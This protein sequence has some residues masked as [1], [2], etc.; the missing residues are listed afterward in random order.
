M[1]GK[2][3]KRVDLADSMILFGIGLAV[4]YWIFQSFILLFS[5]PD[6][7]F[8]QQ[9]RGTD[10]NVLYGRLTVFC[11]FILF[12]SHVQFNINKRKKAE[13]TLQKSEEKYRGILKSIEEGYY[14]VDSEFNFKFFNDSMC[15][16][17]GFT[18]DELID[19]NARQYMDDENATKVKK[20]FDEIK[21]T[22]KP[23]KTFDCEFI[24][25]GGH[26]RIIELSV[27]LIAGS[28]GKPLGFRGISRDVTEKKLLEKSLLD[29]YEEV[30][31]TRTGAI[32]GLA[33]LA[34]YRDKETGQH[35]ERIRE[36]TRI[37]A[38]ELAVQPKYKNYVTKDYLDDIYLS[39]ILHDIGKV[40]TPDSILLKRDK[41]TPEEI[42]MME[43]HV[44]LG[45][46]ALDTVDS[47]V[48]RRSFLTLG[49][50]IAYYHHEKWDGT[51]YPKG[52]KG[53]D[54][55]LSARLVTLADVYDALTSKRSYKEAFSHKKARGMVVIEKGKTFDPDVVSAFLAHEDEFDK[56]REKMNS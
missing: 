39:S 19:S 3:K 32:L 15:Q 23:A 26:R 31:N 48:K 16:M 4:F 46:S 9:L 18:K 13:E 5:S 53:E 11:L 43:N 30:E 44:V 55:P 47:H 28:N 52:L 49:K 24:V 21:L 1:N 56:I 34:E 38:E 50:E 27:S 14:E 29:S 33:K 10:I 7:S 54:I 25:K 8:L 40:G 17:L 2:S 41:L 42:K 22:G 37:I 35:L 51:G 12:G 45:G 36:Y 20:I 6:F